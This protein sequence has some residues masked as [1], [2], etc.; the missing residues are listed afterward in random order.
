MA[1]CV[2]L[3]LPLHSRPGFSFRLL[4]FSFYHQGFSLK[5]EK[6]WSPL[7]NN[8]LISLSIHT[9]H[10]FQTP[11][12]PSPSKPHLPRHHPSNSPPLSEPHPPPA[13]PHSIN[14]SPPSSK[15][16]PSLSPPLPYYSSRASTPNPQS[17]LRSPRRHPLQTPQKNRPKKMFR[18]K[19]KKE[20]FKI[21]WL[22]T[23]VMS[24]LYGLSWR[25]GSN[26][27]NF[28]RQLKLLTD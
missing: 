11:S 20:L 15:R 6:K 3:F 27:R 9:V 12:F 13:S 23:P 8:P 24:K 10:H 18:L 26:Q 14:P 21:I 22:K 4:F 5:E 2:I 16:P 19:N 7:L 17:P 1:Y 28:K 25:W